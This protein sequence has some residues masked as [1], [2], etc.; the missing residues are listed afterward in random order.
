MAVSRDAS[1]NVV[2]VGLLQE[3]SVIDITEFKISKTARHICLA[4]QYIS[5]SVTIVESV[6]PVFA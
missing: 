1:A 6:G 4:W 3:P 2:A 5:L